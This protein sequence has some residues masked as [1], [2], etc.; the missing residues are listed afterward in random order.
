MGVVRNTPPRAC[1]PAS[2]QKGMPDWPYLILALSACWFSLEDAF[3]LRGPSAGFRNRT[4]H[5]SLHQGNSMTNL[6]QWRGFCS[7]PVARRGT[8][9][10]QTWPLVLQLQNKMRYCD[11]GKQIADN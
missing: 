4:G 10:H 5:F 8:A 6:F 11:G 3:T 9:Q 1:L 2:S 7:S